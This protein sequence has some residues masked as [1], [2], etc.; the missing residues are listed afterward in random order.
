MLTTGHKSFIAVSLMLAPMLAALG[1]CLDRW[2]LCL[3]FAFSSG[4]PRLSGFVGSG[5][6]TAAGVAQGFGPSH[7]RSVAGRIDG[8]GH[9]KIHV[10]F[11]K[12]GGSERLGPSRCSCYVPIERDDVKHKEP[13]RLLNYA[14]RP[15]P[16]FV[17]PAKAG[18]HLPTVGPGTHAGVGSPL[19]RG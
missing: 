4:A 10:M 11:W 5:E 9:S 1:P 7:P 18:T 19:A 3:I 2:R 15:K 16:G 17:I 6:E 8:I 12:C 14:S 13:I